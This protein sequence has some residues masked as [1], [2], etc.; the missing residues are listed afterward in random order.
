MVIKKISI[1]M[2][3]K[4]L[5]CPR[6]EITSFFMKKSLVGA[7]FRLITFFFLH[8]V[9]MVIFHFSPFFSNFAFF[10]FFFYFPKKKAISILEEKNAHRE[11]CSIF[12]A[13]FLVLFF[14]LI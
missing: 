14:Q 2:L 13:L 5:I 10:H 3:I 8:F 9:V 6:I 4:M 7:V 1:K 12:S 11:E